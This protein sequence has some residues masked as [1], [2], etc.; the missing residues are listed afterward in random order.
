VGPERL[1]RALD[2]IG[3]EAR[4]FWEVEGWSAAELAAHGF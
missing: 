3:P 1:A 2:A 4:A